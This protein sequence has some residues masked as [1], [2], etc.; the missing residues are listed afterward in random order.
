VPS[1]E[2]S[3]TASGRKILSRLVNIATMSF[4]TNAV[5]GERERRIDHGDEEDDGEF[6]ASRPA[7]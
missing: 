4:V 5:N 2:R 1:I 6:D 7:T 3:A